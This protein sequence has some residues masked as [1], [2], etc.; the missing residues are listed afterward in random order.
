MSAGIANRVTSPTLSEPDIQ[1]HH[2]RSFDVNMDGMG[3]MMAASDSSIQPHGRSQ[4]MKDGKMNWIGAMVDTDDDSSGTHANT[5]AACR[6]IWWGVEQHAA[7]AIP[8]PFPPPS[9]YEAQ[10]CLQ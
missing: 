3:A 10:L 4:S 7:A 8:P 5:Q 9:Q 6:I 2:R 1:R